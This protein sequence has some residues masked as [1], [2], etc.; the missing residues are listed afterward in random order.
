MEA[1]ERKEAKRGG[2]KKGPEVDVSWREVNKTGR[3]FLV[4]IESAFKSYFKIA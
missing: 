3:G 4:E 1:T 2:R